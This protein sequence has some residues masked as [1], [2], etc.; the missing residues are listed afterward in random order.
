M[1]TELE[2]PPPIDSIGLQG[3]LL[4]NPAFGLGEWDDI[5]MII[6]SDT[7]EYGPPDSYATP[8]PNIRNNSRDGW[9]EERMAIL[10]DM[11]GERE[12]PFTPMDCGW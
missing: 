5:A 11:R 6:D 4:E 7:T 3:N 1:S 2:I 10:A 8:T 9:E 12:L